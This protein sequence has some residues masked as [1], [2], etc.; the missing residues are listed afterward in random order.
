MQSNIST[1][2]IHSKHEPERQGHVAELQTQ[3]PNSKIIEAVFPKHDH[4]PFI[5]Q[6]VHK[7]EERTG[8]ALLNSE[9]G[10]ILS[11]RKAWQEIAKQNDVP[12][13]HYLILESDSKVNN[14]AA[15]DN[16]YPQ[17][18]NRFD[19]F[20]WGAW[21]GHSSIK[22]S[23]QITINNNLTVGEP[24]IYSLYGAYGYSINKEAAIYLLKHSRSIY[25]PVDIYK[26][27]VNPKDISI[28]SVKPELVTTW[29][30]TQST[31]R[32]D[33]LF[34]KLKLIATIKIFHCRNQIRAYFC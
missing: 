9:I 14:L 7:S 27:Y 21:S 12:N 4:V 8:K 15:I 13:T 34:E 6:L 24:L 20:F 22:R 3:F 18:D 23:T 10:V 33:V 11:H 16:L 19:L 28:G 26:H 32:P 2:I 17:I 30:T 29:Q 25:Y 5:D 31:I 1:F